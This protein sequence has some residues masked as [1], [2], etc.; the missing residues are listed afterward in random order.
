MNPEI[1]SGSKSGNRGINKDMPKKGVLVLSEPDASVRDALTVL[2]ESEG[3]S[4]VSVDDCEGL[5]SAV[6]EP[7]V[8]ALITESSL[9]DCSPGEILE[10]CSRSGLPVIFTG[11]DLPLQG[12]VDLIR[13]GAVDFLDKPF[14]QARLLDLLKRLGGGQNK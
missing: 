4:V 14:P 10:H 12:A 8:L 6:E 9:P 3:W 7:D 5:K 1:L 2:L 13:Q 11:H